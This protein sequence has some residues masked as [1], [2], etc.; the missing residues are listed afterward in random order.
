MISYQATPAITA[1]LQKCE[2]H[3]NDNRKNAFFNMKV[4]LHNQLRVQTRLAE[5]GFHEFLQAKSLWPSLLISTD[6]YT[7]NPYYRNVPLQSHVKCGV[8]ATNMRFESHRLFNANS[9]IDDPMRALND[10]MQLRAL[11][12]PLDTRVLLK[13]NAV[14]MMNTPSESNTI[15]PIANKVRGRVLTFGLGIGYFVYMA[16]L[17]PDVT[18]IDVVELDENVITYFNT[19]IFPYLPHTCPVTIHHGDA[20]KWMKQQAST[21]DHVFVDTYQNENDGLFWW[22]KGCELLPQSYEHCH[23]WIEDSITQRMR[24]A[25]FACLVNHSFKRYDT[26]TRQCMMKVFAAYRHQPITF[27]SVE[28]I[29][30]W[31]YDHH[32]YRILAATPTT[33]FQK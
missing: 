11:D 14:W 32:L 23:Y 4:T 26:L 21:Y 28:D 8:E 25:M 7:F 17:N 1:F 19:A 20:L 10:S 29:Q 5:A 27:T 2:V 22:L 15:D 16:M 6:E 9:I 31:L 18:S 3:L 30:A 12:K 33:T 24:V 13:N